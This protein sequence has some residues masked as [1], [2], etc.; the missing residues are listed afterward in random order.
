MNWKQELQLR[1][2]DPA[3]PIEVQ[4][5]ICGHGHNEWPSELLQQEELTYVY[6]DELEHHLK[7]TRRGCHGPVRLSLAKPGDTEAF[8]GGMA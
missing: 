7:C 3:Q 2:L 1:D 6:L 5:R 8:V 4:C